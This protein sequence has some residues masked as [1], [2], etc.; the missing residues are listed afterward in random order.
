[1]AMLYQNKFSFFIKKVFKEGTHKLVVFK[2]DIYNEDRFFLVDSQG[3][4]YA[5]YVIELKNF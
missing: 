1:M 5:R 2:L 4:E 3:A